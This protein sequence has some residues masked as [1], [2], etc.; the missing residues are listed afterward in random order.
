MSSDESATESGGRVYIV[1][2]RRWL[3]R[4]VRIFFLRLDEEYLCSRQMEM[5][6]YTL[7]NLPHHR[8]RPP[9]NTHISTR[10][11]VPCLPVNLYNATWYNGLS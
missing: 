2:M 1:F 9:E 3:N 8:I 11:A 4:V 6:R 10:Y 7:G 5:N